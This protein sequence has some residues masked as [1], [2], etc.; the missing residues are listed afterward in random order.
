VREIK[1]RYDAVP[2]GFRFSTRERGE[3]DLDSHESKTSGMYYLGG[4]VETLSDVKAR[5]T[6]SDDILIRNM[7]GNHYEKI[8]TN[9]NS[10]RWSQPLEEGDVVLD[11]KPPKG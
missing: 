5:A 6:K 9:D 4:K 1:E 3:F 2:Y 11:W 7:E 10:W 8:V